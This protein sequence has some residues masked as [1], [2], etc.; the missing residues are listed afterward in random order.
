MITHSFSL[1]CGKVGK[2]RQKLH[3]EVLATEILLPLFSAPTQLQFGDG[4]RRRSSRDS[5][6]VDRACEP[7]HEQ[8]LH[9]F[10]A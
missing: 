7:G 10:G 9:A 6:K 8:V 3:S 4:Q 2:I 1:A 5:P